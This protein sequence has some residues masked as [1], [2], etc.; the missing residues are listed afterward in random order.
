M[1]KIYLVIFI[2]TF[3]EFVSC[4]TSDPDSWEKRHN[5]YQPPQQVMDSI[6]IKT[7]KMVAEVGAGRGRYV[8]HMAKR[9]GAEGKVYANDIDKKSLDYL[10]HRC[11]RDDIEN[12]VTVLGEINDPNL[13]SGMMDFIYI[14]NTYHHL[15]EPVNL[16]KN[17]APALNAEGQL[18]II[19]HD[20]LKVP[21]FGSHATEKDTVLAQ[22]KRAGFELIKIQTF[23]TRDNIYFFE[24][25]K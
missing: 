6:G 21:D 22:G 2:L 10:K 20:P 17:I 15:E 13:P 7:G 23:L 14:V 9:V 16:L 18:V 11:K 1:K 12:V 24:A 3:T 4:Q 8:V 19:E 5:A 25:K